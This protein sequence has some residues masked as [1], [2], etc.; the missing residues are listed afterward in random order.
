MSHF[1][2]KK[3]RIGII[4]IIELLFNNLFVPL[5]S[6]IFLI[7]IIPN[8]SLM[9]RRNIKLRTWMK[10]NRDVK[11]HVALHYRSDIYYI[12]YMQYNRKLN[13]TESLIFYMYDKKKN[14]CDLNTP[15]PI[16]TCHTFLDPSIHPSGAW[17]T[18]WTVKVMVVVYSG[19]Y[20]LCIVFIISIMR[21]MTPMH[22]VSE[23]GNYMCWWA[24]QLGRKV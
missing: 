18:L 4:W 8:I 23:N 24:Q 22:L 10:V 15:L 16:T 2:S 5:N 3:L 6:R 1:K 21:V 9:M 19:I 20:L 7:I 12:E 11:F 14:K 13:I 17:H